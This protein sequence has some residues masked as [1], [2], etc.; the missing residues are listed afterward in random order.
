MAKSWSVRNEPFA[1]GTVDR[2]LSIDDDGTFTLSENAHGWGFGFSGSVSGR[3]TEQ[4]DGY[5]LAVT[6][7]DEP[8]CQLRSGDEAV[9]TVD[10]ACISIKGYRLTRDEP[11]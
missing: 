5:L 6:F 10:G 4:A 1:D 11:A 3:W 7:G 8:V 2:S 9:A